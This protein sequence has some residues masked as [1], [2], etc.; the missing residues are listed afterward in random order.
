MP[1]LRAI[2][3]SS[4]LRALRHAVLAIDVDEFKS[5]LRALGMALPLALDV[6]LRLARG[7][8]EMVL[9]QWNL[10]AVLQYLGILESA[11]LAHVRLADAAMVQDVMQLYMFLP[12]RVAIDKA[13]LVWLALVGQHLMPS[14]ALWHILVVELRAEFF[15][16]CA[17]FQLLINGFLLQVSHAIVLGSLA[18]GHHLVALFAFELKSSAMLKMAAQVMARNALSISRAQCRELRLL[19]IEDPGLAVEGTEI[20]LELAFG[21]M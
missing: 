14:A 4:T 3:I 13:I 10:D 16:L 21:K 2:F 6:A 1:P 7:P 17:Y 15:F 18:A 20:L 5:F 11:S 19:T 12:A 8:L 9:V